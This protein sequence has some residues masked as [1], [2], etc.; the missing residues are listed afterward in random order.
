MAPPQAPS[1]ENVRPGVTGGPWHA[2]RTLATALVF[3]AGDLVTAMATGGAG[4]AQRLGERGE[5]LKF[6][7]RVA[8]EYLV[9]RRAGPRPEISCL[10]VAL[11]FSG[12]GAAGLGVSDRAGAQAVDQMI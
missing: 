5:G 2:R 9:R 3:F 6:G 8:A 1:Q 10:T 11:H 4:A 12:A 7:E